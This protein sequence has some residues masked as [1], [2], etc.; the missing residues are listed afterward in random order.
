[1]PSKL[2]KKAFIIP[3]VVV[4]KNNEARLDGAAV[5]DY[6][7]QLAGFLNSDETSGLNYIT[8][9]AKGGYISASIDH[10]QFAFDLQR[11]KSSIKAD[12]TDKNHIHFTVSIDASGIVA[13]SLQTIDFTDPAQMAK[14][15]KAVGKQI[16]RLTGEAIKKLQDDLNTDALGLGDYLQRNHYDLWQSIKSNWDRGENYFAKST[17]T[18]KTHVNVKSSGTVIESKFK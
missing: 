18:V 13:E 3:T 8:G 16:K 2:K 1:M 14:V 10:D 5:F 4:T 6:K 15:E 9:K 7:N 11:A 17:I 12:V